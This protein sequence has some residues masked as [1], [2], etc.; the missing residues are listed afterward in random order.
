MKIFFAL[1]AMVLMF[2]ATGYSQGLDSSAVTR[3]IDKSNK[4]VITAIDNQTKLLK[5]SAA[6]S[7]PPGTGQQ[8]ISYLPVAMFLL[9][10]L[11]TL[12]KLKKDKVKLSDFLVDK[13]ALV[14][15]KQE[16]AKVAAA[17]GNGDAAKAA[18]E[19]NP[20]KEQSCSRLV[21]F[22]SGITTL[23]LGA[24]V[25]TFYFYCYFS[26]NANPSLSNL[27][28]VLYGLGLGVIPYGFNKIANALK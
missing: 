9:I 20:E 6:L 22:I 19:A 2:L 27:S 24:C 14:T 11:G 18:I 28:T 4:T 15:L 21:A 10:L 5:E 25:T 16:T 23:A 12:L 7:K 1:S 13:D 3:I 8:V 26:G 17:T